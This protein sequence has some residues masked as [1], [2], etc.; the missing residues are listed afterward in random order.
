MIVVKVLIT[1]KFRKI[2]VKL[3]TKIINC[4]IE[5]ANLVYGK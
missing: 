5:I 4:G 3:K 2:Y 1:F